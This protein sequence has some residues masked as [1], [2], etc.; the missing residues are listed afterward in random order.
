VEQS[1]SAATKQESPRPLPRW[2]ILTPKG[3]RE[4]YESAEALRREYAE[5][6]AVVDRAIEYSRPRPD[7]SD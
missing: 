5:R 7:K 6:I 2:T 4:E 1:E 3:A